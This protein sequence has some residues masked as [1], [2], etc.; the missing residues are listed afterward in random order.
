MVR[1]FLV[2]NMDVKDN[3]TMHC[4]MV[5]APIK[6]D[7]GSI[8]QDGIY[9]AQ[10]MEQFVIVVILEEVRYMDKFKFTVHEI[11]ISKICIH[12]EVLT[13]AWRLELTTNT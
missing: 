7:L 2:Q 13:N 3:Y 12:L 8:Y 6:T 11:F 10:L 5:L 1:D 4:G 9:R